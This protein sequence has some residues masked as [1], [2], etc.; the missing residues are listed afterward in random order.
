MIWSRSRSKTIL[1]VRLVIAAVFLFYGSVKLLGGQYFYDY[2]ELSFSK[3]AKDGT[4][5]VWAF[6]GYSDF[7]GRFT[8]LFEFVPAVLLL[9]RK[10]TFV[11]AGAL[12]AVG[13]NITVMDFAFGYPFVKY[14]AALYTILCAALVVYDRAKLR[15]VFGDP[16]DQLSSAGQGN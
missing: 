4:S 8:G 14:L 13:L 3:P 9:F 12:F 6:Y 15:A 7:Y 10:T 5:L 2:T 16:A 1:A 11:A